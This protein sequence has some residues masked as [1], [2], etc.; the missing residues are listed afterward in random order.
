MGMGRVFKMFPKTEG[1]FEFFMFFFFF[2]LHI[3]LIFFNLTWH[4]KTQVSHHM[5]P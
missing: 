5:S 4:P 1:V 3:I 2:L